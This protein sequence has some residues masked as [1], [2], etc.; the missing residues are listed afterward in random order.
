MLS[1]FSS[2]TEAASQYEIKKKHLQATLSVRCSHKSITA[3]SFFFLLLQSWYT[4][5]LF[6]SYG[7]FSHFKPRGAALGNGFFQMSSTARAN[8][9]TTYEKNKRK[10]PLGASHGR[11]WENKTYKLKRSIILTLHYFFSN[12]SNG[13]QLHAGGT[14]Q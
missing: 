8:V 2:V 4:I 9:R 6:S 1:K 11:K 12:R 13:D 14:T 3:W 5:D 7:L 10:I